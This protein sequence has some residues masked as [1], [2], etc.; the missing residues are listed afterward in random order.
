MNY[1]QAVDKLSKEL[2]PKRYKHSLGVSKTAAELAIRFNADKYKAKMAG[3]LHDCAR[4]IPSKSLLQ[5]ARTFAIVVN[6]V[7]ECQP[8]LLH[9]QI[10]AFLAREEFGVED[11][12]I[13]RAI[14]LHTTGGPN[15]SLLDK[16]V[17]L[18]DFIEPN[19][20]FPGVTRLR[21]LAFQDLDEALLAAFDHSISFILEK[22]Q[23]IHPATI[24][25]RNALLLTRQY[26][27]K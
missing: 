8:I 6:S 11:P 15:M 16:I 24:E 2:M 17:Y 26:S 4:K 1:D 12:D 22:E 13:L 5:T 7:E 25:S 20:D 23:L 19:R 14:E 10:G 27:R 9:A 3:L 21:S 18:A